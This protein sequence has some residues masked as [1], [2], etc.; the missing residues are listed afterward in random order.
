MDD[1][2]LFSNGIIE[3]CS[4]LKKTLGLFLKATSLC[5]NAQKSTLTVVGLTREEVVRVEGYL[6]FEIKLLQD[7]FKYLGFLLKAR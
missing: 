6:Q 5:I 7:K 2:L 4:A 3:D 1:I